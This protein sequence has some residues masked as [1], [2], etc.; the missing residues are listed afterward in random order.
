MVSIAYFTRK[1]KPKIVHRGSGVF[2]FERKVGVK[3][4]VVIMTPIMRF[5]CQTLWAIK[6]IIIAIFRDK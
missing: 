2:V 6:P 1:S 4:N 5:L 3:C